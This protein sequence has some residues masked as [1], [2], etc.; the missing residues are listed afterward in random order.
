[1]IFKAIAGVT[2][3]IFVT[4]L[5][6]LVILALSAAFWGLIVMLLLHVLYASGAVGANWA[7]GY[8]WCFLIGIPLSFILG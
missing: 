3:G 7:L 6:F 5:L 2:G 8:G 1:M 4:I